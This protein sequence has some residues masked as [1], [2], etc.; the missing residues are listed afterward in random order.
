MKCAHWRIRRSPLSCLCLYFI[1]PANAYGAA[2]PT[3][4]SAA[5]PAAPLRSRS[6]RVSRPSAIC[7]SFLSLRCLVA[8][9]KRTSREAF[10][11]AVEKR[12]VEQRQ[13]DARDQAGGHQRLPVVDV[14][15]DQLVRDAGRD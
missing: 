7:A 6:F 5:A 9:A 13:R 14:A 2:P 12:V 1:G 11:E 10:D 3:I 8:L 15:D 4:P